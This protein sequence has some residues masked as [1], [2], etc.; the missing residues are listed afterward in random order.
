MKKD[1]HPEL[2]PVIFRDKAAGADF[3]TTSTMTSDNTEKI[4][5][6]DHFVVEVEV[7]SA[8]H[9][10]YTGEANVIDTAGRVE[11]FKQRASRKGK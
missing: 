2:H 4:D 6:V 11:K 1:T 8:S 9:P 3:A 5:G 7:S 10:H